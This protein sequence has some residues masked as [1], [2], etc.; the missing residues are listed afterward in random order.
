[1]K[2]KVSN[3]LIFTNVRFLLSI[4]LEVQYHRDATLY[5]LNTVSNATL[6]QLNT[7]SNATL[8]Q[9]N[10]VST[11]VKWCMIVSDSVETHALV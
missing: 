8:Y 4:L 11:W 6:Y 1:M 5:Q 2:C 10:T 3:S 7:V 9:L